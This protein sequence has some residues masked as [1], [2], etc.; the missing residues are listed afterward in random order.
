MSDQ[1]ANNV[2]HIRER[3]AQ[4]AMRVD[5]DPAEITIVAV[6]KT[7]PRDDMQRAYDQGMRVFGESRVQE[8]RSKLGDA[9]LP[10]D[11]RLHMIGPLQTNKIRQL[12]PFVDVL[13][14]VDRERLI[15]VLSQELV[16]QQRSLRV[17]LQVNI[18]GEEQKSGVH[19][20]DAEALLQSAIAAPGV[21]PVGLM[22]MAPYG[23]AEAT[24]RAVF[25]GLRALRDRLQQQT[26]TALPCLSM[27]MSDDFEVAIEEGSTHVRIGRSLFGHRELV[28]D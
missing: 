15:T 18:S 26:G 24:Q 20:N 7:F 13:E 11:A 5:R 16:K 10:D 17:Y 6:S 22:T 14:T 12:L 23:A 28:S 19:P 25:D 27:G 9:P 3:I 1:I 8:I 21:E 2:R 4:A